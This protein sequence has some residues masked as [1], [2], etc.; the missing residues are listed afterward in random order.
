[1]RIVH[2]DQLTKEIVGIRRG[3]RAAL[4][5]DDIAAGIVGVLKRNLC[6]GDGS[7]QGRGAVRAVTARR[8]IAIGAGQLASGHA[9]LRR[10]GLDTAQLVVDIAYLVRAAIVGDGGHAVV[11]VVGICGLVR[12]TGNFLGEQIQIVQLAVLQ[13]DGCTSDGPK[14]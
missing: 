1:M 2:P 7:H 14:N 6:L 11:F 5:G 4:L 12:L 8:R 3:Q 10:P 13:T 9:A